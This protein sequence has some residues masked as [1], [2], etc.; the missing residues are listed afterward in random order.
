MVGLQLLHRDYFAKSIPWHT[1]LLQRCHLQLSQNS[2]SNQYFASMIRKGSNHFHEPHQLW[3][4]SSR[5]IQIFIPVNQNFV[6]FSNSGVNPFCSSIDFTF[7]ALYN[8]VFPFLKFGNVFNLYHL[9]FQWLLRNNGIKIL[10]KLNLN[11]YGT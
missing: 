6:V 4:F 10:L 8:F 5:Q 7:C 11:V 9:D 2:C 1:K 3:F